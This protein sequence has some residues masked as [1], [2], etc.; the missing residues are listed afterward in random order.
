MSI[1]ILLVSIITLVLVF[2]IAKRVKT[3]KVGAYINAK[4]SMEYEKLNINWNADPN[5]PMPEISKIDDGINI[6]FYLNSKV[7]E[8]IEEEDKGSIEFYNVYKY[9]LGATNDEGYFNGQF[10]YKNDQLPWGEFYELKNTDWLKNFPDDEI[11]LNKKLN[12]K[13]LRHFV[14]FFKGETF[15]CIASDFSFSYLNSVSV[16]LIEK[17]PEQSFEHYL[18]MFLSNFNTPTI[19][20]FNTY[21]SLYL[22]MEDEDVLADVKEDIKLIKRN[23]DLHLFLKFINERDVEGFGIQQL[24]DIIKTVEEYEIKK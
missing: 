4:K 11:L 21:L 10:R 19:D 15:E 13:Y 5:S 22:Q 12:K 8:H 24:N 7:Y 9:R 1:V 16:K 23:N 2:I 18:A 20:N 6:E 3:G 14:F 17:Y